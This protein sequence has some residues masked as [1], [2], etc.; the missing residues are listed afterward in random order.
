MAR[1]EDVVFVFRAAL[2]RD[3][4]VDAIDRRDRIAGVQLDAV[5]VEELARGEREVFDGRAGE[6]LGEVD[7]VVGQP[8]FFREHGDR[9]FAGSVLGQRFQETLTDHAVPDHD[10]SF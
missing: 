3:A 4:L 6:V 9:E 7:A 5:L 10:N 2:R 1:I 8:R